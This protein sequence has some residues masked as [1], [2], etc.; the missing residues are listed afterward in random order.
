[1]G[2][3][4]SFTYLIKPKR[5]RTVRQF[6]GFKKTETEPS[7]WTLKPSQHYRKHWTLCL[8]ICVRQTV[9]LTT[10]TEFVGWWR[11]VY[12]CTHTLP[13]VHKFCSQPQF[14]GFK[15]TETEPSFWTLK[16]SQHYRKHWTLCLQICVRQTVRLTTRTEFVGWWRNVYQCTHTLPPVHKFCSQPQKPV[17]DTSC[18]DQQCLID[19]WAICDKNHWRSSWSVDKVLR[20]KHEGKRM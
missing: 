2:E 6:S 20:C 17:C 11:N 13:P 5:N 10:C 16:P 4:L 9:R 3:V 1:M 8:Q 7:F 19:T 12:Q 18:C 15:K 14:S